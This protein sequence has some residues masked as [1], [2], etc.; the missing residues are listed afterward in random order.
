[1]PLSRSPLE[2]ACEVDATPYAAF[3]D[4]QH[5]FQQQAKTAK[6]SWLVSRYVCDANM[7]WQQGQGSRGQAPFLWCRNGKHCRAGV[8]REPMVATVREIPIIR[9]VYVGKRSFS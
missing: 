4:Q 6:H 1:M 3:I 8:L 2:H 7:L 5:H 9:D